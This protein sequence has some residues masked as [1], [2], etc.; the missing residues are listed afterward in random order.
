MFIYFFIYLVQLKWNR[1]E[2]LRWLEIP[3]TLHVNT[4][5]KVLTKGKN[6][7]KMCVNIPILSRKKISDFPWSHTIERKT[8]SLVIGSVWSFKISLIFLCLS[9]PGFSLKTYSSSLVDGDGR[10]CRIWLFQ[11]VLWPFSFYQLDYSEFITPTMHCPY[12]CAL[13]NKFELVFL[14]VFL[15]IYNYKVQIRK[16]IWYYFYIEFQFSHS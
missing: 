9:Y 16:S 2:T 6:M 1:K 4:P 15:F 14:W 10:G 11:I 3:I 12:I 8:T 13:I 5:N 7:N